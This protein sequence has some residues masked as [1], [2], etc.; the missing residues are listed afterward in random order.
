MAPY[1]NKTLIGK[2]IN[3]QTRPLFMKPVPIIVISTLIFCHSAFH[4]LYAADL[5][6]DLN[7]DLKTKG[8]QIHHLKSAT[9]YQSMSLAG[10]LI[11]KSSSNASASL[12]INEHIVDLTKTPLLT[13][14]WKT[15][16]LIKAKRPSPEKTKLGDDFVAR[17]HVVAKGAWPWQIHV[18]NYV[19]SAQNPIGAHWNNPYTHKEKM[20]VVET[21]DANLH[22]WQRYQRNIQADFKQY[23]DLNVTEISAYAIM[24]DTDN[25]E[26]EASAY[27]KNIRFIS[28]K[29]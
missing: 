29:P 13:W 27:F 2:F 21:G 6:P 20:I 18:L 24:T 9:H 15:D 10:E 12:L 3:D 11:I 22:L 17:I 1:F 5:N 14:S 28:S 19:W 16:S 8:W 26:G 7:P 4:P 23:F 25:T